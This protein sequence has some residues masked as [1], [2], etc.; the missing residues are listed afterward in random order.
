ML[1]SC[2]LPLAG[3]LLLSLSACG[4]SQPR[5][6]S[7]QAAVQFENAPRF[8]SGP[9]STACSNQT[10]KRVSAEKCGC[11]QAAANLTLSPSDQRRAAGFF[12]EPEQ[13][14]KV[15]LSDTPA[16]EEFW[17]VWARFADT[18]E[19]MCDLS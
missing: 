4:P 13:L 14:Q 16:N 18:A 11:V 6:G 5:S 1:K 17:S 9:I 10:R 15:K 12:N 2:G 3:L 8:A 7:G 19:N